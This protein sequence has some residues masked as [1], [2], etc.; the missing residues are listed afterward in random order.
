M[1]LLYEPF[2]TDISVSSLE[3]IL[4]HAGSLAM[5]RIIEYLKGICEGLKHLH[6]N[7]LTHSSL[8]LDCVLIDEKRNVRIC[9]Y[10]IERCLN[11][12]SREH[13]ISFE[14]WFRNPTNEW[15][16]PESISRPNFH[17]KKTDI[18]SVGRLTVQMI[19]GK[20]SLKC[21][22][23][24]FKDLMN[25]SEGKGLSNGIKDFLVFCLN[26]WEHFVLF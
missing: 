25:S 7:G 6:A 24:G 13:G 26:N 8:D 22:P 4:D 1:I 2:N 21:W 12:L 15:I 5:I 19:F 9:D 16:S 18:W 10:L 20:E 3:G 17:G 23:G 14:N 11:D